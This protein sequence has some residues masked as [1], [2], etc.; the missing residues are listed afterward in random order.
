VEVSGIK[1][2]EG[3]SSSSA[4]LAFKKPEVAVGLGSST[5]AVPAKSW[6]CMGVMLRLVEN[7]TSTLPTLWEPSFTKRLL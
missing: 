1:V 3:F 6:E 2:S 7:V 4:G 5:H